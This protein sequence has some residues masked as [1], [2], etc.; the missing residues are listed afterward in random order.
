MERT[1]MQDRLHALFPTEADIPAE[2][3]VLAPLHQRAILLNGEMRIWKG[4]TRPVHSP[5]ALRGAEGKLSVHDALRSFSIRTMVAAKQSPAS[6][7][8]LDSIVLGNKSNFVNT[9]VIQ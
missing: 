4:E 3:R 8:L 7:K 9:R 2:C 6:K 5:V 1:E